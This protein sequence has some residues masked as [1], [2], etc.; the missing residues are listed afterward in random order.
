LPIVEQEIC[1]GRMFQSQQVATSNKGDDDLSDL[2]VEKEVN[3]SVIYC[4]AK[5][6]QKQITRF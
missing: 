5:G 4:G 3:I 2:I 6:L 1:N